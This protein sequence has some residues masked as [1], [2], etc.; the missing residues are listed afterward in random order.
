MRFIDLEA[1][2]LVRSVV[3]PLVLGRWVPEDG[4]VRGRDTQVLGNALDPGWKAINAR[5]IWLDHGDLR[6][7]W[8]DGDK[9]RATN[10]SAHRDDNELFHSMIM[11]ISWRGCENILC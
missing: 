1:T 5:S 6:G 10:T 3:L 7:S 9:A 11:L 8:W 2:G 4:I